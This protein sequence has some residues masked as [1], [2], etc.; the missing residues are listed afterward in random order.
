[1]LIELCGKPL[2]VEFLVFL[3]F[4]SRRRHTRCLSD[5]SSDVCSSD[6]NRERAMRASDE[7]LAAALFGY[8]EC[9]RRHLASHKVTLENVVDYAEDVK[10]AR[11]LYWEAFQIGRASCRERVE[12]TRG[13]E[14]SPKSDLRH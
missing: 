7:R 1:M 2:T 11:G 6:L 5:W 4:S 14:G 12:H 8:A 10:L 13:A 3:V 9:Q